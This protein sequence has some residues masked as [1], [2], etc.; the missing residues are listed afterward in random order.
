MTTDELWR[1]PLQAEA[2]YAA[3][4]GSRWRPEVLEASPSTIAVVA[5]RARAGEAPGLLVVADHQTAGRGR[6]DRTWVTPAGVAL[7]FSLLVA[8][9]EVPVARWPWLPLLAGVAVA[10]A[11]RRVAGVEA[12]LKWPNDVLS[13]DLKLTGILVERVEG[14][15]HAS[16]VVGIGINV[17]QRRDDLP[18]DTATSVAIEA[19][20]PVNRVALLAEVVDQLARLYDAWVAASGD[21]RVSGLLDAYTGLCA[22]IGRQV[23]VHLPRD[24]ELRGVADHV[25]DDGRLVVVG[26]SGPVALGAG[27]VVHVRRTS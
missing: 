17:L 16:A 23:R 15:R 19:G 21:A 2:V 20:R 11:V 27:D 9:E 12:T 7:T 5:D 26:P 14:P 8:P 6:L 10:R 24:E 22:T 4:D 25:D 13:G 3:L 18:V 1:L